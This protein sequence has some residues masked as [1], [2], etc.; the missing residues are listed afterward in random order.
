[1]PDT[2]REHPPRLDAVGLMLASVGLLGVVYALVEGREQDWAAWIW[3]VGAGGLVVLAAFVAQQ[4]RRERA[5]GSALLP[6]RLFADRGFS[7][8]LVTQGAFQGSLAGFALVVTV[9]VQTGLGWSAIHAGLTLLPF[10]LGAFVGTAI[11]VPLGTRL[12]QVVMVTG[13]ALQ[14]A[15]TV[16]ALATVNA[17]GD[18]LS[19]WDLCPALAVAGIGLGLLV[20][21]LVDVALATVPTCEAGAASGVYGTVQQVGAALGVAVIGTVFFSVVGSSYD[22]ESLRSGL[23]AACWVAAGGYALAALASLLL[24]SRTQVRA[25]Q[26]AVEAALAAEASVEGYQPLRE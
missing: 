18:A 14:S 8:G 23:L 25:H 11:S 19:S 2:R 3:T 24:P 6:M 7:T 9:Y 13:A 1:V 15:A 4:V 10:S 21:P 20:V 17:R 26:A 12:G 16:W 5:T 22:V